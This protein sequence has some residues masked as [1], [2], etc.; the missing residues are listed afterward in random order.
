MEGWTEG[1]TNRIDLK[2]SYG[3]S[4][5]DIER[6][7]FSIFILGRLEIFVYFDSTGRLCFY[8]DYVQLAVDGR[9][10]HVTRHMRGMQ[11]RIK[12]ITTFRDHGEQLLE[13]SI[14]LL[15]LRC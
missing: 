12:T 14:D 3:L 15:K 8:F 11:Y 5:R 10:G 2:R 1:C 6:V 9:R 13:A 7:P 4:G